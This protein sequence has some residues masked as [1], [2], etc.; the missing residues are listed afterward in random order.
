MLDKA[1]REK[2]RTEDILNEMLPPKEYY[3]D[4]GQLWV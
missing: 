4:N 2:H 3:L 1:W